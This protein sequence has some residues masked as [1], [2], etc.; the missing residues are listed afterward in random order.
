MLGYFIFDF[1]ACAPVLVYELTN[2]L[3]TN[4]DKKY[5]QI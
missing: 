3:T 2:G 4:Y 1:L 5:E